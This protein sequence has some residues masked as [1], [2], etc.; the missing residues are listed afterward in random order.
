M[1][2]KQTIK[3]DCPHQKKK[4]KK[5]KNKKHANKVDYPKKKKKDN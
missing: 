5:T 1:F 3:V 4:N 2:K